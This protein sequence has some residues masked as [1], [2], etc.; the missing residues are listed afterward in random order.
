LRL[1]P[2]A[3]AL[4]THERRRDRGGGRPPCELRRHARL[5]ARRAELHA[6]GADHQGVPGERAALPGALRG[7]R[8]RRARRLAQ[9][10][11]LRAAPG[12]PP[13]GRGQAQ[14]AQPGRPSPRGRAAPRAP[15][16]RPLLAGRTRDPA[17]TTRHDAV[18][19]P[20]ATPLGDR[21]RA[22]DGAHA[23][24]STACRRRRRAVRDRA[25]AADEA[26]R[27]FPASSSR[28]G[29]PT[30]TSAGA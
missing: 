3:C 26:A 20:H 25:L 12:T 10:C 13:A 19:P 9:H 2:D 21:R 17:R 7:A 30:R 6:R 16:A 23:L 8:G 4:R 24:R 28:S 29:A 1:V 27:I 18:P 22:G 5:P 11:V 15:R 14:H